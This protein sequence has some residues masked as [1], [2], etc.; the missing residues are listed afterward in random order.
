MALYV[1]VE[2]RQSDGKAID[3]GGGPYEDV[4]AAI[5]EARELR[6]LAAKRGYS[7][8]YR[9]HEVGTFIEEAS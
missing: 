7:L 6:A 2:H 9:V 3:L 8:V 1:V 4:G 5:S